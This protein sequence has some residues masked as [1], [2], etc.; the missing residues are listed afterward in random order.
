[1]NGEL[2]VE[3]SDVPNTAVAKRAGVMMYRT[4]AEVDNFSLFQP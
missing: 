1:V 3:A 4:S 2:R